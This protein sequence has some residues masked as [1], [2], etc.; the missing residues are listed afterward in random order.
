MCTGYSRD[1]DDKNFLAMRDDIEGA[2][3]STEMRM[4]YGIRDGYLPGA[5]IANAIYGSTRADA[6]S[7]MEAVTEEDVLD[8]MAEAMGLLV[9]SNSMS[10]E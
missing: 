9:V 10:A 8:N 6:E 2:D 7:F 5:M 3:D 4:D 1:N